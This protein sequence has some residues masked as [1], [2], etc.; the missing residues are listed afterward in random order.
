MREI[1][2]RQ[3]IIVDGKFSRFH[4]WGFID[5]QFRGVAV[6]NGGLDKA[7]EESE[8]YTGYL[9][10]CNNEIFDGDFFKSSV[11]VGKVRMMDGCWVVDLGEYR[12]LLS[13]YLKN[14][15]TRTINGNVHE[16]KEYG[17]AH[18]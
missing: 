11:G 15:S 12:V 18:V 8:Q 13:S 17:K 9:D 3:P 10:G 2:F 16:N 14:D 5:G 4:Y 1:K 6:G 7:K